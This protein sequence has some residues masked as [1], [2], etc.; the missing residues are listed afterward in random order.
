MLNAAAGVKGLAEILPEASPQEAVEFS[1]LIRDGIGRVIEEI[2]AQSQLA[3][4]ERGE[5]RAQ[6]VPAVPPPDDPGP[7]LPSMVPPPG[8]TAQPFPK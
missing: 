8:H 5:L 6:P 1:G 2:Q 3:Q 4:M 7:V